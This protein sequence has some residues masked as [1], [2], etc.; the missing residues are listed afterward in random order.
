MGVETVLFPASLSSLWTTLW[1]RF[2]S[3]RARSCALTPPSPARAPLP[4]EV[5]GDYRHFQD[6]PRDDP[7]PGGEIEEDHIRIDGTSIC[8]CE[9]GFHHSRV[10]DTILDHQVRQRI[11]DRIMYS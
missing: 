6:D 8:S 9:S 3:S 7:R 10:G 1:L 4:S 11:A 5:Y 2:S